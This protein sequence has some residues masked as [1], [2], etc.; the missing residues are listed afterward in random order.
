MW[1]DRH[2]A[3]KTGRN[4]AEGHRARHDR[5]RYESVGRAASENT[6]LFEQHRDPL[7]EH[8][9]DTIRIEHAGHLLLGFSHRD[10]E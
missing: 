4:H 10:R 9:A 1:A 2:S 7:L 3:A 6:L 5:K 8:R